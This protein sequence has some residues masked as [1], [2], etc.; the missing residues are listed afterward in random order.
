MS[1]DDYLRRRTQEQL[2]NNPHTQHLTDS[3]ASYHERTKVNNEMDRIR[4]EEQRRRDDERR[5]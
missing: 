3:Q 4:A 5:R 1:D 2:T